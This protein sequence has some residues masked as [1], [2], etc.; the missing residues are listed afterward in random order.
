MEDILEEYGY[1]Q[2]F[3]CGSDGDF[4]GREMYFHQ[5]GNYEVL[6]Y[7][8]AL[9]QGYIPEGYYVWWGYEDA[10]LFD[11]AETELLKI[12]ESDE[13]FNFTMLTVDTHH[14]DGFV[15]QNCP[16]MYD[17]QLGNVLECTD[18][19]VY[20]FVQ[21]C[22]QQEFYEDTV[23]VITGDHFRMDSSLVADK[24]RRLYNCIINSDTEVSGGLS[25]RIYTTLDIFPTTLSAMGFE[26]EGNRLGLGTDLFSDRPTISEEIGVWVVYDELGKFSDFYIEEFQ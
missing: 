21:W 18:K 25:N 23:I 12:S 16:S 7:Y 20:E 3:L 5:H 13:P 19:Q 4:A 15:C 17:H 9:E 22:Q 1:R 8:Y 14:V 24:E 6:D 11:I 26:I 10:K 2:Y